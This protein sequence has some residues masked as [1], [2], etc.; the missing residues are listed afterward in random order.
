MSDSKFDIFLCHNSADKDE[1]KKIGLQL[2]E[3]GI[4]P[5][6]DE[7]N[8]RPGFPWTKELE[9]Q[10][11]DIKAAAVFVGKSGIGPWQNIEIDALLRE[12]IENK[13]P[14]M[15]VILESCCNTPDIPIFLKRFTWVD[16]RKQ[17]PNPLQ[18][19][20]WGITGNPAPLKRINNS[21]INLAPKNQFKVK[22][23]DDCLVSVY[24][25]LGCARASI[26][27]R[28]YTY[29]PVTINYGLLTILNKKGI[30]LTRHRVYGFNKK[31]VGADFQI[32]IP[33][34]SEK[35][36]HIYVGFSS[37]D[38]L[39]LNLDEHG[40]TDE[41]FIFKLILIDTHGNEYTDKLDNGLIFANDNFLWK[42]KLKV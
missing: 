15:P 37:T 42:I 20:I 17:E 30:E 24:N 13:Y 22:F 26:A 16:F 35:A 1:V 9:K 40:Y 38:C 7:W 21:D 28:N 4:T 41:Q 23:T 8:L 12:F 2:I 36:A 14:V 5:W 27:I 19:L 31:I 18:Q 34:N 10:I 29:L 39:R 33:P 11:C 25:E 6:L 32:T 3:N